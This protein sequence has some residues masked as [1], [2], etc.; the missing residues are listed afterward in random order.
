MWDHRALGTH[1]DRMEVRPVGTHFNINHVN[2]LRLRMDETQAIPVG[3]RQKRSFTPQQ[4]PGCRNKF[5]LF[6]WLCSSLL[7]S[8]YFCK[9]FFFKNH[10]T[11]SCDF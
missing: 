3:G 10:Q 11:E 9:I 4:V 8:F 5:W 7:L 6:V 1:Q 2:R